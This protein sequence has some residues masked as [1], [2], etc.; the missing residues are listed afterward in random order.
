MLSSNR[1]GSSI[2]VFFP[3]FNDEK[4]IKSQVTDALAVLPSL[5]DDFEVLIVNE[6]STDSTPAVLDVPA[7]A[8]PHVST[9]A[10]MGIHSFSLPG[11]SPARRSTSLYC[12]SNSSCCLS[13]RRVNPR[14][15]L[16]PYSS[17]P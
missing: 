6:G 1:S 16:L 5:T 11:A 12:G 8:Q 7:H 15:R 9:P 17:Q 3:A 14:S 10:D 2:S 4:T 13:T